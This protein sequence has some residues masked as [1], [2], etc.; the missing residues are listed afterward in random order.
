[1]KF[2]LVFV[3]FSRGPIKQHYALLTIESHAVYRLLC[4][5]FKGHVS[6]RVHFRNL[7]KNRVRKHAR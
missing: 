5:L 7:D 4:Q 3:N 1:M 6:R 2:R